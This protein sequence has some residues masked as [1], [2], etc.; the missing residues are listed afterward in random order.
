M[1]QE[2]GSNHWLVMLHTGSRSRAWYVG[3]GVSTV[4]GH[5]SASTPIVTPTPSDQPTTSSLTATPSLAPTATPTHVASSTATPTIVAVVPTQA[6][7]PTP[8]PTQP[9][10]PTPTP[11]PKLQPTT[12]QVSVTNSGF[13]PAN[14]TIGVGS[15]VVWTNNGGIPHTATDS[16]KF[17]SGELI[18]GAT[19]QYTFTTP[20]TYNYICSYHPYMVGTITVK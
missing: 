5:K 7:T 11:S 9:P 13:S 4:L 1:V 12:V 8:T 20:G 6:T 19:Y 18:V 14:I 10:K 3:Y 16:G 2:L 17:D 15:T